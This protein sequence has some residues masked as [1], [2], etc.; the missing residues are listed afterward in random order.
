MNKILMYVALA[1]VSTLALAAGRNLTNPLSADLD[2][3]G[4]SLFGIFN[5]T[6]QNVAVTNSGAV[7]VGLSSMGNRGR[8]MLG[9]GGY[10]FYGYPSIT[11]HTADPSVVGVDLE[12]GSLLLRRVSPSI[13]ELWFKTG[14]LATDWVRIAP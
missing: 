7:T 12:S 11:A 9:D 4:F 5:L 3:G 2:G 10:P 6:A 13:G 14:P 1:V 8:V